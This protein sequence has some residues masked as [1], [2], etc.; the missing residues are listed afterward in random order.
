MESIT[1]NKIKVLLFLLK[2]FSVDYNA[3]SLSK[4]VHL[5]SM[6]ALKI[7]KRLEKQELV[8]SKK[9]GNA[10]FYKINFASDYARSYLEFILRQETE[11]SIP[12]VKRWVKE[13]NKLRDVSEI[14]LLFG[15]VLKSE[16]Y[17]DV[18]LL[19]VIKPSDNIKANK[20]IHK[21]NELG[22]K[23]VN[24]VKQ[25]NGDFIGN[26]KK[27]DKVLLNAIKNGIVLFGYGSFFE[28][29]KDVSA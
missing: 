8:I 27:R 28:V 21:I 7:L 23:R 22:V 2:D 15:S 6:G 16:V 5:T 29:I 17:S 13:L 25:T 3:N 10:V 20:I 9:I 4:K 14:G 1:K 18:D 24:A 26:L 12:R 19:L 11:Q